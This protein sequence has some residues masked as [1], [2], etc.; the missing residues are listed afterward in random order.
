MK[1]T[2]VRRAAIYARVSTGSQTTENQVRELR[3]VAERHGWLVVAEFKD[4]GISGAKGRDA[5]PGL[6]ALMQ[7]VA[8]RE[9]DMVLAW[10]VDRLGRSLQNLI[11]FLGELHGKRV[12]LYLHQ[13]GLDTSTPAGKALFQMMGVFAEFERAMI[14]ERVRSGLARARAQGKR[15]GRPRNNNAKQLAAVMR[16]R[17]QGVGIGKIA[18]QLRVGVSYVQRVVAEV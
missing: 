8:R 14:R 5:R 15:L 18:R 11:E 7:A 2:T 1:A 4:K 12:D 9:I 17:G 6:E 13:Q 10:S 16:L 3:Q